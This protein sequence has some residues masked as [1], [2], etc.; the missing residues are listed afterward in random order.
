MFL[1]FDLLYGYFYVSKF[2]PASACAIRTSELFR[3][4][5]VCSL[6]ILLSMFFEN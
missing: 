3:V 1:G 6:T 4:P 2:D 5:C